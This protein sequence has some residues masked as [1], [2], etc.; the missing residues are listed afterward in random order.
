MLAQRAGGWPLTMFLSLT[1][2]RHSSAVPIF[3]RNRVTACR[4]LPIC[5]GVSPPI[6][7]SIEMMLRN[8]NAA[9]REN[10][11]RLSAGGSPAGVQ[12]T[13]SVLTKAREEIGSQFEHKY[14][15]FGQAPKFPHRPPSIACCATGRQPAT[16]PVG[17]RSPA[18]GAL[19]LA[20]HGIWRRVRQLGGGFCRYSVDDQWMIPHFEKMLYDNGQ[21][22]ALYADATLATGDGVFRRIALET[23]EWAMREMQSPAGRLLLGAR[24]RLGRRGRQ[25]LRV[26]AG[27]SARDSGG[28]RIQPVRAGVR[29]RPP[30]EL[31]E[32]RLEPACVPRAAGRGAEPRVDATQA[33]AR[34]ASA[35]AKLLA[36]RATRVRP[37]TMTRC[38]RRGT[39]S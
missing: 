12:I 15:G 32:P 7:V 1:T 25:V 4:H 37:G 9:V 34:L 13:D 21:L 38:S 22:L 11:R 23:A 35:R 36:A 10:F 30:T 14:G 27:R 33:A 6:T 39:G 8:R 18:H 26:D 17:R 5:A 2:I 3:R 24:R 31:R 20:R 19:Q 29:P 28:G 16:R